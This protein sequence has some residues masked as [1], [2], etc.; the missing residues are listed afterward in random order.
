MINKLFENLT[1]SRMVSSMGVAEEWVVAILMPDGVARMRRAEILALCRSMRIFQCC[2]KCLAVELSKK[3]S[4]RED[5]ERRRGSFCGRA[6][7]TVSVR[8]LPFSP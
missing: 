3:T 1:L 8:L 5:G 4:G 2:D 6:N 7:Q